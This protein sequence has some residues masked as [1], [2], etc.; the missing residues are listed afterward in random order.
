MTSTPADGRP[1]A[2]TIVVAGLTFRY[3]GTKRPALRDLSLTIPPGQI[4]AVLGRAGAGKTTLCSLLAGFLP[5]F[6]DGELSGG[7]TVDGQ[8]AVALG[9]EHLVRH[10]AIV[11]SNVLSQI[12]G[13]RFSVFEE[14]AFSLENMGLERDT[15]VE[16]A[17][18]ALDALGIAHLRDRSPYALSGGQQQ[19]M[20]IAA[21][22]A[23]RPPVLLLDEPTASLD[24]PGAA[25]LADLLRQLASGGTTVVVAEHAVEW[26]AALA[27]RVLLLDDGALVADGTPQTV[28][29][30]GGALAHGVALP[31]AAQIARR[32][33]AA[34]RWPASAAPPV[35]IAELLAGLRAVPE[36]AQDA[37]VMGALLA[38]GA[39]PLAPHQ[40]ALAEGGGPI[41]ELRAVR[42]RY[43]T[44]VEAL[45][46][47]SFAIGRGERV[48][49]LGRNGAGK[50]T[51][52]RH[53]NG[54]LRPAGGAVLVAGRDAIKT[55]VAKLARHVGIVFQDVRNQLFAR[56]VRD[57]LRFGPRN[58]GYPAARVEAL[59]DAALAALGLA[60]VA[61]EHPYDLPPSRRR[62]TAIAAVLAMDPDLLVLDEPTAGLDSAGIGLLTAL[63]KARA[64]AGKSALVVSHDLNFCF[65]ALDRVVLLKDGDLALDAPIA[66]M[67][68]AAR[69]LLAETVGLPDGMAA[70][71]EL[72]AG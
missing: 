34:G 51:A 11:P 33:A 42:Y 70:A 44:G 15:I 50:S 67:G 13:A 57:E 29:G 72:L 5:T 17:E 66:G 20:V 62:L 71:R 3:L 19:R 65:A 12:S 6:Y 53:L 56:T 28:L 45:R 61:D 55:D 24:P 16:R 9:P 38:G 69:D 58:L 48:A 1:M 22:L 59:V 43:P 14:V 63:V 10:V 7:V 36:A 47:V 32:L 40:G 49:L 27:Q 23:L 68:A 52:V 2:D 39:D 41:V 31:Q 46:G 8:D 37:A 26:T 30:D 18:W 35:T 60:D 21:A 25:D 54:L 64:E 4:C